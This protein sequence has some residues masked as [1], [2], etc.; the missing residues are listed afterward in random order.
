MIESSQ[1]KAGSTGKRIL[2]LVLVLVSKGGRIDG[3]AS[4]PS[5]HLIVARP[6]EIF[7]R[8]HE[9]LDF[10][11]I[12]ETTMISCQLRQI[13]QTIGFEQKVLVQHLPKDEI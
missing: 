10:G 9:S 7:R 4:S 3:K 6:F 13:G 12:L 11:F 1:K 2:V 8:L 5:C